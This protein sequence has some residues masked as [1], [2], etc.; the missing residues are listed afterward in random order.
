M[1]VIASALLGV[2]GATPEV[3]AAKVE[4]VTKGF[5]GDVGIVPR[6]F[7]RSLVNL[8]DVV[9]ENPDAELPA[10]LK[11]VVEERA[12]EGKKPLE[13]EPEPDDDKGYPV[14]SVEF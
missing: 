14:A 10:P 9:A 4:D 11:T 3:I 5:G 6:Q 12:A 2:L 1:L 7:L 8:F 13:Y